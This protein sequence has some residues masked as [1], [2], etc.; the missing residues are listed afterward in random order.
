M[1]KLNPDQSTRPG[2]G[3]RAYRAIH[4]DIV[5]CVLRPGEE[6]SETRLCESYGFGKAPIRQ[7][8]WRLVQEGYVI[9]QPR[10]GHVI[11][12]VTLKM[13]RDLFELRLVIE[14][15][16]IEGACGR[17]DRERLCALN[18]R[19]T[20]GYVPGDRASEA[21]FVAANH[22]FHLEIARASGNERMTRLFAEILDEMTRM[23][24]LAFVLRE[25]PDEF[26]AEHDELIEA[27]ARNDVKEARGMTIKHINSV[28]ALTMDGIMTHTNLNLANIVPG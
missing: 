16:I 28:R 3:E 2:L 10:R 18:A 21:R 12:P 25:R 13:V 14:P 20:D 11:S 8:L 17:V 5:W 24:H 9:S 6:V 22:A 1:N 4:A 7:A 26:R 15:A 27:L 23:L 19:C